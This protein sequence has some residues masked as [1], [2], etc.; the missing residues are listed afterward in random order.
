MPSLAAREHTARERGQQPGTHGGG[1]AAARWT[2]D[3]E[4]RRAGEPRHHLGDQALA[5]EEELGVADVERRQSL[6]RAHPGRV[7]GLVQL[8]ALAHR[9]Q[10]ED[11]ARELELGAP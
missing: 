6:E 10:L 4:Q 3:A 5:P 11:V 7:A 8:G 1:L 2:H 9:L